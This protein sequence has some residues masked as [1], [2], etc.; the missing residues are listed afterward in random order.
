MGAFNIQCSSA[1]SELIPF[2]YDYVYTVACMILKPVKLF[3]KASDKFIFSK[4]NVKFDNHFIA[5]SHRHLH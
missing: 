5:P 3:I 2:G 1:K 4:I